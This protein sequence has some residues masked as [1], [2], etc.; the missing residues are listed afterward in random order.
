MGKKTPLDKKLLKKIRFYSLKKR[1][2]MTQREMTNT[3]AR[4]K[5]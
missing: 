1:L 2:A 4:V 3:A 5:Q